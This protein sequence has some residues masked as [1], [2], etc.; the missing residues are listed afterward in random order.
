MNDTQ[1]Q[2]TIAEMR[3]RLLAVADPQRAVAAARFFPRYTPPILGAPSGYAQKLGTEVG[4]RLRTEGDLAD[5]TAI[6]DELLASGVMEEAGAANEMLSL[7]WRRYGPGDWDL[8]DRWL[9]LSNCWGTTDSLCIKVLAPLVVRD[10]PPMERL[11]RWAGGGGIWHRRAAVVCFVRVARLGRFEAELTELTDMLLGDAED[12]VQK[13]IGWTLKE[14]C[15]GDEPAVRA[16][17]DSRSERMTRTAAR[18]AREGF[19]EK[20]LPAKQPMSAEPGSPGME[21]GTE[22]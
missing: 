1:R 8:F 18:Y 10:G 6:A 14:L 2:A 20:P 5:V 19:R 16:Y 12:L 17:L 21:R 7:F 9:G 3:G 4:R 22:G 13:A 15:K 11:R